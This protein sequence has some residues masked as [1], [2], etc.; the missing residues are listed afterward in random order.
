[1]ICQSHFLLLTG[2]RTLGE[3][4]KRYTQSPNLLPTFV[5]ELSEN[6]HH[7]SS[8]PVGSEA[9]LALGDV[10]FC[11]RGPQ[12][13]RSILERQYDGRVHGMQGRRM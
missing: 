13:V 3:V 9:T 5:L 7:A 11:F 4:N 6:E 1:M 2:S 10:V 8:D 12:S